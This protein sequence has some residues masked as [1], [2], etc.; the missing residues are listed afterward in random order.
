[1]GHVGAAAPLTYP[2][3]GSDVDVGG[4]AE[5]VTLT[6]KNGD[7]AAAGETNPHLLRLIIPGRN[8][9]LLETSSNVC[10]AIVPSLLMRFG[11][12]ASCRRARRDGRDVTALWHMM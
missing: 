10:W 1:M 3:D 11:P 5:L 2:V 7:T 8:P 4:C 6:H 12:P 9:V